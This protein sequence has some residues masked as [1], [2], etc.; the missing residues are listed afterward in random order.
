MAY[1][2]SFAN[3]ANVI[4]FD[5][6][7]NFAN[8]P[9]QTTTSSMAISTSTPDDQV[10]SE[11]SAGPCSS[12]GCKSPWSLNF[13]GLIVLGCNEDQY[14]PPASVLHQQVCC[15]R[16]PKAMHC[17]ILVDTSPILGLYKYL[18]HRTLCDMATGLSSWK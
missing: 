13:D 8:N 6:F 11:S 14:P 17:G 3:Y 4:P 2:S 1:N 18:L 9:F 10:D 7:T 15:K 16:M 5:S 12:H